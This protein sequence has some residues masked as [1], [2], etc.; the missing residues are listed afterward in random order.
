[1]GWNGSAFTIP[2]SKK[3][4]LPN[5]IKS[6]IQYVPETKL[7]NQEYSKLFRHQIG[8][9]NKNLASQQNARSASAPSGEGAGKLPTLGNLTEGVS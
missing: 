6:I 9:I 7:K 2:E 8:Y 4:I 3:S 5:Y 1:M